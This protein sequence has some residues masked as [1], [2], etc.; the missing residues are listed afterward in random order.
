MAFLYKRS[1]DWDT[2][3]NKLELEVMKR[4]TKDELEKGLKD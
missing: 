3:L 2:K 1:K 4:A